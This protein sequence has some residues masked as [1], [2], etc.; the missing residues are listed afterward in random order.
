MDGSSNV[1][2]GITDVSEGITVPASYVPLDGRNL[3]YTY[4]VCTNTL[5]TLPILVPGVRPGTPGTYDPAALTQIEDGIDV[6]DGAAGLLHTYGRTRICT[7]DELK[8]LSMERNLVIFDTDRMEMGRLCDIRGFRPGPGG[9]CMRYLDPPPSGGSHANDTRHLIL[10][11]LTDYTNTA[12]K[13]CTSKFR[14]GMHEAG[15]AVG[16]G[17]GYVMPDDD[18]SVMYMPN[19]S[20]CAL[21]VHDLFAVRAVYESGYYTTR[22]IQ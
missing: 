10:N 11:R 18:Y 3:T 15:H 2:D 4:H 21:T 13:G 20:L 9:G 1:F 6:W 5:P 19:D 14:L 7:P 22:I 8:K 16:F 17:H 12:V